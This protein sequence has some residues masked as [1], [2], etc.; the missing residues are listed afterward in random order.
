M[1]IFL[2]LNSSDFLVEY[3]YY[4]AQSPEIINTNTA[5]FYLLENGYLN[6][7]Q[8]L[9][10]D[11]LENLT[12][13]TRNRSVVNINKQ[14]KDFALLTTNKL[15]IAY[16][17]YDNK[18]TDTVNLPLT[19]VN[20][21]GV[22]YDT[23]RL[24]LIQGFSFNDYFSAL[25]LNIWV[26]DSA[27][28]RID[29]LNF[30]YKYDDKFGTMNPNPFLYSGRQ[31]ASYIEFKVP[32]LRYLINSFKLDYIQGS[33]SDI[34]AYKIT[35]GA[36]FYQNTLLE[37][38]AGKF[39]K[40]KKV[41]N[42]FFTTKIDM[43]ETS[44]SAKDDFSDIGVFINESSQGDYLE[45]YGT[46]NGEI[47]G[48]YMNSLNNSGSGRYI[49]VNKIVITEQLPNVTGQY[50]LVGNYNPLTNV[51]DLSNNVYINNFT[52]GDYWRATETGFSNQL[53]QN[54]KKGDFIVYNPLLPSA[55][56]VQVINSY[57]IENYSDIAQFI[58]TSEQEIIQ[59]DNFNEPNI[60]RPVLK[61]GGSAL[62]YKVDYTLQIY[63]TNTNS[64]IEK[65]GSY[66]SFNPQKY[67]KV[68][69]KL[70]TR[71]NFQIF[72]V[73]NKKVQKIIQNQVNTNSSLI[74]DSAIYSKNI[75]SFKQSN[76]IYVGNKEITIDKDG[77]I[78]P[79]SNPDS[80][81]TV[82]GQGKTTVYLSPF[83]TFLYFSIYEQ[84]DSTM[85]S[86]DLSKIGVQY[87]NFA[88]KNGEILKIKSTNNTNIDESNGQLLFR[89]T[90]Q[91]YNQIINSGNDTF[92][93][94]SKLNENSPETIL[95][96]GKYRDYS[97]FNSDEN[98]LLISQQRQVITDLNTTILDLE[99]RLLA[100][101][102]ITEKQSEKQSIV[103]KT[104]DDNSAKLKGS[105]FNPFGP[106]SRGST[107]RGSTS[108]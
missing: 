104:L 32:S 70:N 68:L 55:I 28:K 24:H 33:N 29:L 42:Q 73:Y 7:K 87:L 14:T 93:I 35:N 18:L 49:T 83:D 52:N 94:T 10:S 84:V 108:R 96:T 43:E 30:I 103:D 86:I 99:K 36:G 3:I 74:Q 39:S 63:N 80:N 9:N 64:T 31:Y 2:S 102:T 19:F 50:N 79:K 60:F 37:I 1:N 58:R 81:I 23:V 85:I 78:S 69:L 4:D 25:S 88:N 16:N 5:P 17:D 92:Y 22:I 59:D 11:G 97:K 51:P 98:E 26:H 77:N 34:L 47:F 105:T 106:T 65:T 56:K 72:D 107:T 27:G 76:N 101:N 8:L 95:Y 13:N 20:T 21:E 46:Y 57:D 48:D 67:G 53:L 44:I 15:G 75:T 82:L 71:D 61:F 62:S 91:I 90:P 40:L 45:F 12:N 54:V 100:K 6:S 66:V 38:S 89:V 41:D